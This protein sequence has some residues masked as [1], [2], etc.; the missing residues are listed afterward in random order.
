M[1]YLEKYFQMH[2]HLLWLLFQLLKKFAWDEMA[3]IY[4]LNVGGSGI[5]YKDD[6]S[7]NIISC[8]KS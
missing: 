2:L 1:S 5:E 6:V 4:T 3:S 7:L 8:S